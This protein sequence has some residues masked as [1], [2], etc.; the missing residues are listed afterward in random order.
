MDKHPGSLSAAR[1]F[2]LIEL[3]VVIAV[4][5]ILG[6][7]LLPGLNGAKA[8]AKKASCQNQLRQLGLAV[9]MY[10]DDFGCYPPEQ[11]NA[12][13]EPGGQTKVWQDFLAPFVAANGVQSGTIDGRRLFLCTA[14]EY[15]KGL[16]FRPNAA[17]SYNPWGTAHPFNT[18]N[19]TA[20]VSLSLS[21]DFPGGSFPDKLSY[22]SE[23]RVKQPSDM[24]AI[25]DINSAAGRIID[26]P[27]GPGLMFSGVFQ[28]TSPTAEMWPSL[29][30]AG[31]ANMVFCDGHVGYARQTNWIARTETARRRWN[32]D[33]L[34]HPETW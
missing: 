18:P 32:Y 29:I 12:H 31:G 27:M 15:V 16:N 13:F 19:A 3:L 5:G 6:S 20:N 14:T 8:K 21:V 4:V 30:H 26:G 25:G 1:A 10:V 33:N 28:I 2:T 22:L 34:P 11:S 17:Y 9:H 7:L 23:N 24:I